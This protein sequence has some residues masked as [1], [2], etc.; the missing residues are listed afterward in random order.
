M[1]YYIYEVS[2]NE[3]PDIE[4]FET[5]DEARDFVDEKWALSDPKYVTPF[6]T[7]IE[8]VEQED[9]TS[10][11]TGNDQIVWSYDSGDDVTLSQ[12]KLFDDSEYEG[13]LAY[14]PNF[15]V[16]PEFGGEEETKKPEPKPEQL[17]FDFDEALDK[18]NEADECE[19]ECTNCHEMFPK[20]ECLNECGKF[21]C[22]ECASKKSLNEGAGDIQ[23]AIENIISGWDVAAVEE[24]LEDTV[25]E[26]LSDDRTPIQ[27][28]VHVLDK[29]VDYK[30]EI[31]K[32]KLV[33]E[34]LID[35][36]NKW[37]EFVNKVNSKDYWNLS[38][39][40]KLANEYNIT[41]EQL[42]DVMLHYSGTI[43]DEKK[44]N[45]EEAFNNDEFERYLAA[46]E[47]LGLKTGADL[48]KFS[49][50][51]GGVKDKELL[52]VLEAE[53]NK[54]EG[55][56]ED[57]LTEAPLDGRV[58]VAKY[59]DNLKS[60]YVVVGK[61]K[62][63]ECNSFKE[64]E[65]K[66]KSLSAQNAGEK[67]LIKVKKDDTNALDNDLN[68]VN[69]QNGIETVNNFKTALA[70][71]QGM[72][73]ANK[74]AV[75]DQADQ[76]VEDPSEGS[77]DNAG[78][79]A[80]NDASNEVE[81]NS[82]ENANANASNADAEA[83]AGEKK[84]QILAR[85]LSED[86][87]EKL[88]TGIAH[89]L[90][91]DAG[92]ELKTDQLKNLGNLMISALEKTFGDDIFLTDEELDAKIKAAEDEAARLKGIKDGKSQEEKPEENK[93]EAPAENN[94]E[95]NKEESNEAPAET[96]DAEAAK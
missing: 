94:A 19:V 32:E 23:T 79:D 95:E 65:G 8:L 4:K 25:P 92:I 46:A 22:K 26:D 76:S 54:E 83:N 77:E 36:A 35:D 78:N 18:L 51:H 14:D 69:W 43:M 85:T 90:K 75:N 30:K 10:L 2:W 61:N 16:Y 6:I 45:L 74:H 89:Q 86:E 28:D 84:D 29:P 82:S 71:I 37:K 3:C 53:A 52:K 56:T 11:P 20:D 80:G 72:K 33:D 67:F 38:E 47:K 58:R 57:V 68:L 13:Q 66:A 50:E 63:V 40:K 88:L 44:E 60:K 12:P 62:S 59:F 1:V 24:S 64:A 21:I 49:E 73:Q 7:E 34:S 48:M 5:F 27:G 42:R 81:N 93:E 39:L 87:M 96:N 9:G 17:A 70:A 31:A 41:S 15:D 91:S 55:L